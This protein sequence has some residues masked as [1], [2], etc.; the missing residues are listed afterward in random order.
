M[1]HGGGGAAGGWERRAGAERRAVAATGLGDILVL[2]SS[3]S[4]HSMILLL[5]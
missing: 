5:E 4:M 3:T 2:Y 1:R